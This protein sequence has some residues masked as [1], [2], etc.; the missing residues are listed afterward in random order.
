[1][2]NGETLGV[3]MGT[4]YR[5]RLS[6]GLHLYFPS[7]PALHPAVARAD[8]VDALAEA[9]RQLGAADVVFDSFDS[10]WQASSGGSG[11]LP[12]RL[13]YV[14]TLG[15]A[16][17][18]M[19]AACESHH[20]RH[21]N[22]GKR[23]GLVLRQVS[24]PAAR[25]LIATVTGE[26]AGRAADR[27]AP[28]QSSLPPAVG[29]A[30]ALT[31]PWGATVLSA[32]RGTEPLAAALIGWGNRHAF[33]VMGGSTPA[34]YACAAATWLHWTIMG[35]LAAHGFTAYNLGGTPVG[36]QHADN[37]AHGLFRFKTGFGARI[38]RCRGMRLTLRPGHRRAHD[39]A[40]WLTSL[41]FREVGSDGRAA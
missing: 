39:V 1:M 36:A 11:E 7:L 40:Q 27:G 9:F 21:I 18:L 23:A 34:G 8:A 10:R 19:L 15:D 41:A 30:S 24:G 12:V 31:D 37:P 32:W 20:R 28:F 5:C 17:D 26:A 6:H 14:V 35:Q 3:A 38:W 29:S 33:Y 25:E 2:R 22:R 13:E 16:D 4:G